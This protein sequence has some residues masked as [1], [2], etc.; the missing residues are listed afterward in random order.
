MS[1]SYPLLVDIPSFLIDRMMVGEHRAIGS[2]AL[3]DDERTVLQLVS[4]IGGVS[5]RCGRREFEKRH[6][7]TRAAYLAL[8]NSIR[9]LG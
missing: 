9:A 8:G 2:Q 7:R 3:V 5:T 1:R 4:T 6:H